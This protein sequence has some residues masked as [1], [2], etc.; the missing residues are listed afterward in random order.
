MNKR[1]F[2]EHQSIPH[3]AVLEQEITPGRGS[4]LGGL[5]ILQNEASLPESGRVPPGNRWD[6]QVRGF[7]ET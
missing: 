6:P 4:D 3:G 2:Q 7:G 5:Q 1:K